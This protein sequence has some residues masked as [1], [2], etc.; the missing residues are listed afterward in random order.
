MDF[1]SDF[2]ISHLNV[3]GLTSK[4]SEIEYL[5]S[6][7]KFKIFCLSETFLGDIYSD[8]LYRIPNYIM[9][10]KDRKNSGGGGLLCHIHNS[11]NFKVID[12]PT[13]D[14]EKDC[15]LLKVIPNISKPFLVLFVYRSPSY[16]S[17]WNSNFKEY[18]E[19]CYNICEDIVILG[20]FNINLLDKKLSS[21][22]INK[23]CNPLSL[24]QHIKLP[25]RVTLNTSTLIDHIYTNRA[26]HISSSGVIDYS[27]SDHNLIYMIRKIGVKKN[28]HPYY[29]TFREFSKFTPDNI[30]KTFSN[31]DWGSILYEKDCNEMISKFNKKFMDTLLELV[32][33]KK[34]FVKSE[35]LPKWLDKFVQSQ[36]KH[37]DFLKKEE[38]W[39]EYKKQRNFV[40]NL[41]KRK[42]K[43]CIADLIRSSK[44]GDT[45]S[46]WKALNL[47]KT[48]ARSLETNLSANDLNLHFTSIAHKLTSKY[49]CVNQTPTHVNPFSEDTLK[50]FPKFSPSDIVAYLNSVPNTKAN[51][52]DG[53]SVRMLKQTIPYIISILTD[54]F[55]RILVDGVFPKI[56]KTAIV[57]PIFKGGDKNDP[58][59]YRPISVLPILS[60]LFEKHINIHLLSHLNN[61]KFLHKYQ[62][63]F[64]KGFSCT[65]T[66]HKLVT[67]C[68]DLKLRN[69]KVALIFL[70]FSKAFDCVNYKILFHKLQLAGIRD[71]AL[72]LMKSCFDDRSQNVRINQNVSST[73]PISIG[74]PQGSLIAP[75]LFL[76]YINDL[77]KLN[78]AST[79][80][81]YAD[82]TVFLNHHKNFS[83]LE[84]NC[85]KD[86]DIINKWCIENRMVINMTKSHFLLYNS[87]DNI[88]LRID[89]N[90]ITC[91]QETRLLGFD[92][93]N[94]LQWNNHI[95]N[96]GKKISKSVM[97]L[98]LCRPYLNIKTSLLF[99]HQ[100]IFCHFIY[101]IHLYYNL[102]PRYLTNDLFL[103]QKRAFRIIANLQHVP[104]RLIR[105][106][107]ISESLNL[108]TLPV[109]SKYFTSIMGH[110]I[111]Y[112]N[113]PTFLCDNFIFNT[114]N[115]FNFRDKHKLHS[116]SINVLDS[117]I[118]STFN[119]ISLSLRMC[120]KIKKFKSLLSNSLT[121][122]M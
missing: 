100:F 21:S 28:P 112:R 84:Y 85:N 48:K 38:R 101:G 117:V 98:H 5:V 67:E 88:E 16:L 10:R 24:T 45:S 50:N 20:D 94:K 19:E 34:R 71:N 109:L 76:I 25:T 7:H 104:Y 3:R 119:N 8:D 77:L 57:T 53:I 46:V 120:A 29:I 12:L 107:E 97:L 69:E 13:K 87:K 96:I 52:L 110:K 15:I 26:D 121:S 108:M 40:T 39:N 17:E 70:D 32:P 118:A 74:V 47:K 42:K 49:K 6:K 65:H 82:D 56:W 91:K 23:V 90:R 9:V 11:V 30:Y 59:N 31:I 122:H 61:I 14:V 66:V 89:G 99:Y 37:R 62:N 73:L 113:C 64:R 68:M 75:T 95:Q 81:A 92:I 22:W 80:F 106:N 86:L 51:G 35:H 4:T 33:V 58:S 72:L 43:E 63:G 60:K 36:I 2:S 78:L 111:F 83:A 54:M 27:I 18:V 44:S 93:T 55:N 1:K 79:S 103:L 116:R 115:P 105:T 41:I 114:S 102:S